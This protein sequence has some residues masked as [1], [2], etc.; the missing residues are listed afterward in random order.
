MTSAIRKNEHD[1]L[2]HQAYADTSPFIKS[3]TELADKREV[4]A[5]DDIYS[6][7]GIK[8]VSS[9][10][11][12]SGKFYD[13]LVAH[14]L[15]KPIEQSLS[16]ADALDSLTSDRPYRIAC[17]FAIARH[18]IEKKSG[19]QF[20]PQVVAVFLSIPESRWQTL[21]SLPYK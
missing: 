20:D 18:E 17:S 16:V 3:V 5:S 14:K 2:A 4:L 11:P 15:L 13:R 8:L 12:L 19:T 1:E 7:T 21:R 10:T 6:S 9:G